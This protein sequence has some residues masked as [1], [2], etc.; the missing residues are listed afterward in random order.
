MAQILTAANLPVEIVTLADYPEAPEVEE[1]GETFMENA[2]L[3][4]AAAVARTGLVSIADDGGLVIDALEGAPGVQSHRYLGADTPFPVK[5]TR[6]LEM[7]QDTPE[8]ERTCRFQCA[9]VIATP[10][11]QT[12]ECLGTCE[13]RIAQEMRGTHGFGYDPIFLV[14][15][16]GKQMAELPPEV[17]HTISHRGRALAC[18]VEKLRRLFA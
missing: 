10:D 11:G 1:T 15:E 12:F 3:K 5:M 18:A 17:K 9:V 4:A 7:L 2:H 6:V 16:L 13:G 8:P 14:P